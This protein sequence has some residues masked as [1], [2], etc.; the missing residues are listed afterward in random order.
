MA[1][2]SSSD[3][4]ARAAGMRTQSANTRPSTTMIDE[5][6]E[7]GKVCIG[8]IIGYGTTDISGTAKRIEKKAVARWIKAVQ[9]GDVDAEVEL[10]PSEIDKLNLVFDQWGID[11]FE[12][13]KD[14][15]ISG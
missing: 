3:E 1:T 5:A 9:N 14:S 2:Y 10:L 15:S 6:R 7:D 11:S 13:D 12:P 8:E 4:C